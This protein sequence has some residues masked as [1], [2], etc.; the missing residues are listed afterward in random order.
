[1]KK[2]SKTKGIKH[3]VQCHCILPQFKNA[4][5]PVFH[6]FVVFSIIDESDT[7]VSKYATC[8]NCGATHRV[9]DVC[10]SEIVTGKED[11][12]SILSIDDFK[13]SLPSSLFELLGQYQRE[14]CDYEYAQFIIDNKEWDSTIVLSKEEMEEN[15]QGKSVRFL[16]PE[17]FRIESYTQRT[18]F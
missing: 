17:K 6:K 8:N 16:G 7:V 5:D 11:M 14:L 3:L 1:M 18:S 9:Y 4:S 15:I 2:N 10:K 13:F 12:R